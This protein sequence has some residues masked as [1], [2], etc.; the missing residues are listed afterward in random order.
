MWIELESKKFFNLDDA[1]VIYYEMNKDY[2]YDI[3]IE[4]KV[5]DVKNQRPHLVWRRDIASD[6]AASTFIRSFTT[7]I[8]CREYNI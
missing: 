3:K 6:E 1:E 5:I 2:K 4:R 7:L 8:N